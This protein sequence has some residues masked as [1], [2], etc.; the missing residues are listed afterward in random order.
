MCV[1]SCFSS[2]KAQQPDDDNVSMNTN[3][4]KQFNVTFNGISVNTD[5]DPLY[6]GE[7]VMDAYVNDIQVPLW[8]GLLEADS[9]ETIFFG[10]LGYGVGE[11]YSPIGITSL[12]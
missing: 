2:V 5:H 12:E 8:S 7:W 6:T 1:Q 11:Y 3:N 4:S 9:G 10:T